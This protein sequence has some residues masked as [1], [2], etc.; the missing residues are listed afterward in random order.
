MIR[1]VTSSANP[2]IKLA[3]ALDRKKTR[4]ETGLFL[5]EGA[6]HAAEALALGWRAEALIFTPDALERPMVR[7]IVE[8]AAAQG[9]QCLRAPEALLS[10]IAQRDNAQS[11]VGLFH[12]RLGDLDAVSARNHAL[13]VA[14]EAVRDPGNLGTILRTADSVGAGG[15]ILLDGGCDPFSTEAVRAS[16]GSL[17][18]MPLYRAGF[19][20]F[21]AWRRAGGAQLVGT[22]LKGQ[23]THLDA[24]IT[25]PTVLL[26]GNEQSGLPAAM[27][28]ACD[29]LV[30]LP[31]AGRADSLNL[32]VATGVMLYELFRR[33]GF[34]GAR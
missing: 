21:E 17:F 7:A 28:E 8:Q 3:R 24:A 18:A 25:P 13:W 14:L 2:V 6:R 30:K 22:S 1:D 5:A 26:M 34:D 15:V 29:V 16:M 11:L 32:A 4:A 10:A 19:S 20:A 23:T 27:E 9:A 31:M 12:Q 33:T